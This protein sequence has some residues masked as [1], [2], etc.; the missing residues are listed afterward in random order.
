MYQNVSNKVRHSDESAILLHPLR[1]VRFNL[2]NEIVFLLA[3]TYQFGIGSGI[4]K[5]E[6]P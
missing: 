5:K 6:T 2:Q 1:C 3:C 4:N